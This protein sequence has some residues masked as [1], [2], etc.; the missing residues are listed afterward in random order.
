MVNNEV[1]T[2]KFL[3]DLK[4]FHEN[5]ADEPTEDLNTVQHSLAKA[6]IE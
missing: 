2:S 6:G 5:G 4:N 1:R 3:R